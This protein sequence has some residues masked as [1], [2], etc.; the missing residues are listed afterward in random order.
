M[1]IRLVV[2]FVWKRMF[3][4]IKNIF[5]GYKVGYKKLQFFYGELVLSSKCKVFFSFKKLVLGSKYTKI[6]V[7]S[8]IFSR[9]KFVWLSVPG[10]CSLR[11]YVALAKFLKKIFNEIYCLKNYR[12]DIFSL[13]FS[14]ILIILSKQHWTLLNLE[15]SL[16][17]S[18]NLLASNDVQFPFTCM[19]FPIRVHFY[20]YAEFF[21]YFIWLNVTHCVL[22]NAKYFLSK[23]GPNTSE[24]S[25]MDLL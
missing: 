3:V 1:G 17:F 11:Y 2:F 23:S 7:C 9:W 10:H 20:Y 5:F 8:E 21:H 14:G 18:R 24:T 25:N 13:Y 6:F 12:L 16:Y 22:L 4:S 19:D 15:N